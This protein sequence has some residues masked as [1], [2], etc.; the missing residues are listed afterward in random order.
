MFQSEKKLSGS[1]QKI[2]K[3]DTWII[4]NFN[5][6]FQSEKKLSGP[7]QKMNKT[8][9]WGHQLLQQMFQSEK[10]LSGSTQKMNKTDTWVI[11]YFNKCF[12]LKRNCLVL[13]RRWTG[14]ILGSSI[15]LTNVSIWKEVVWFYSERW[16]R[17]ILGSST[18]LTNVSIWKEVVWF[19]SEDDKQARY[20]ESSTTLTNVSI[21]KEVVWFYSG[22]WTRQIPESSTTL[23]NVS[24]WKEVVRFYSEDEQDRYLG[25]QLLQ[26]MFQSEKKLSDSTQKMTKTVTWGIN[27]FNNCF[28]LKRS[29]LVLLR[30][31]TRQILG[32][33]TTLTSVS[34]WK[35]VVL[36]LL[37]RWTGQIL[38]SSTTLTNVSSEK[39]LS[40]STQKMTR[41]IL[42]SIN[43]FNKCFNLK[44]SCL[45][46]L[47]R[48]TRQILGSSTTLT[49]VSIWKEVVWF[50]SEDEQ[51]RYLGQQLLYKCF[52]LKR[53]VWF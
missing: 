3:T 43:Y 51:D 19:Y 7:T 24:I 26:Q 17:Q 2:N 20:F 39:K 40:G 11:N 21:W 35:E 52:N 14:Q 32:S 1:T 27:Y 29:C 4:N 23:T 10:K 45:V 28:N 22:R 48:W 33:L 38:G 42:G 31:W 16:I 5:K 15:T 18:T 25:H 49:T 44:R 34:I 13:H 36:V 47:R 30:S 8:D 6:C 41:L 9:T 53:S 46:L 37:R 50:Y 12:N